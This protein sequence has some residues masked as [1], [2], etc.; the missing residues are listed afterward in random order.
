MKNLI[1][2]LTLAF[3]FTLTQST[4]AQDLSSINTKKKN[5][6]VLTKKVPQLKPITLAAQE[7]RVEDGKKYGEFHVVFCGKEIGQLT[8]KEL[9][10]PYLEMLEKGNVKLIACGFSL[11]K[12]GVDPDE[13]PKG[14]DIV[15]NGIAYSLKLKKLGFYGMEL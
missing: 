2:I 13:L 12:F 14:I 7:M 5:Y 11:N 8:D 15:D 10:K 1:T 3:A 9:M 4:T 6:I